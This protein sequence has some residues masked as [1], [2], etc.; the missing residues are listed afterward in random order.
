[1]RIAL[2][3]AEPD[4]AATEALVA[5]TLAEH[6]P[7]IPLVVDP[8]MVAKGG[9]RL[10]VG[11]DL[12]T[13]NALNEVHHL[14]QLGVLDKPALLKMALSAFTVVAAALQFAAIHSTVVPLL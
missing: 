9:A 3:G 5:A 14:D 8:V 12:F 7:Q 2:A 10:L 1:M 6:A 4:P 11:S 13:G